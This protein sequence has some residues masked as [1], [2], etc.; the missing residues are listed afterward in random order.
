MFE[1]YPD[2]FENDWVSQKTLSKDQ[3]E[4]PFN[5][6]WKARPYSMKD[7]VDLVYDHPHIVCCIFTI[8]NVLLTWKWAIKL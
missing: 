1:Q 6:I 3:C 2:L 5:E 4:D 8:N 7:K